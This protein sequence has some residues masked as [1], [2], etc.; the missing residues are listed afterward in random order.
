[1]I[2]ALLV[3][4]VAGTRTGATW[5]GVSSATALGVA[6]G[7]AAA[8]GLSL[9]AGLIDL[10]ERGQ[11]T[12]ELLVAGGLGGVLASVAA[13][14]IRRPARILFSDI[15]C[16]TTVALLAMVAG[17]AGLYLLTGTVERLEDALF[18]AVSGCTTTALSVVDPNTLGRG[19]LF[20]RSGSQWLGGLGALVLAVVI[21]PFRGDGGEF[22]DRS[23][24]DGRK[25]LA[26]NHRT[27]LRNVVAIY[28]PVCLILWVA[29]AA[30][31]AGGFGSLLLSMA[32]VSTGG[33]V[34]PGDPLATGAV[35]WVAIIGM[36]V[37]GTSVVVLWR[38]VAGRG[39]GLLR[40]RELRSYLFLL[41]VATAL[42]TVWNGPGGVSEIREA[43]FTVT[44]AVSTTGFAS[45]PAGEW[46][47][48]APVLLLLLV[49]I[50]PMSGSVGGGFQLLRLRLLLKAAIREMVR[51]LHPRVVARIRVGDRVASE[52]TVRQATVVQFVFV[53]LLFVTALVVAAFGTELVTALSA[54][55]HALATA[56][57]VRTLDG[58][59]LDP[60]DWSRSAR[61]S[62]VPAM[63]AGRLYFY[64]AAIAAGTLGS[65]VGDLLQVRRRWRR[66]RTGTTK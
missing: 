21:L 17:V 53:S 6:A 14:Q 13:S 32:T 20:V 10:T 54:A 5:T 24:A 45:S 31:G 33:F 39:R 25:P 47:A 28:V 16:G 46:S 63:V 7:V 19:L 58:L 64:P 38:L 12:P 22:A 42:F 26:P 41:V 43:L 40:S 50:G 48:A 59:V 2:R 34:G 4:R 30:A 35:R 11:N 61:L 3:G 23:G 51:Q 49:A 29:Y 56:G 60:S 62:L 1:M 36:A 55:V 8:A 18:E 66:W 27:A 52:N 44:S 65:H 37:A 15:L 57:P 9:V